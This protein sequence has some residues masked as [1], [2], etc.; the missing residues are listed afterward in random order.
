MVRE[1]VQQN[2]KKEEEAQREAARHK[3]NCRSL[4]NEIATYENEL[5]ISDNEIDNNERTIKA[6]CD[7]CNELHRQTGDLRNAVDDL[8]KTIFVREEQSSITVDGLKNTDNLDRKVVKAIGYK[9]AS[10]RNSAIQMLQIVVFGYLL[11]L[12]SLC[13]QLNMLQISQ[14]HSHALAVDALKQIYHFTMNQTNL[15]PVEIATKSNKFD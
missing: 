2:G 4:E 14:F 1:A 3:A 11:T 7:Q 12:G 10:E 8:K 13:F 5:R 15:S 6:L 9:K